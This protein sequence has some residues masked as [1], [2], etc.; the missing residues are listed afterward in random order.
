MMAYTRQRF[1]FL[2]D[3][4]LRACEFGNIYTVSEP[5]SRMKAHVERFPALPGYLAQ[6]RMFISEARR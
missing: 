2:V 1:W 3:D 4:A 5:I 6:W